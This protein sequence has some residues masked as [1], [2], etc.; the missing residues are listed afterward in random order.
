MPSLRSPNGTMLDLLSFETLVI[1][2]RLATEHNG[3]T[4]PIRLA[5]YPHMDLGAR[6]V[7]G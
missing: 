3:V 7:R 1:Y 6:F 5:Q 4:T 2:F